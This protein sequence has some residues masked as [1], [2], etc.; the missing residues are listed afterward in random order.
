[1]ERSEEINLRIPGPTPLPPLVRQA[2]SQQM[3]N[4]RGLEFQ[5]L[6]RE[7]TNGLRP[8]FQTTG[9][10]LLFSASGT[11]GMEACVANTVSPGDKVIVVSIGAFGDR[12]AQIAEVYRCQV[13]RLS[14]P[15]GQA[16]DPEAIL[17]ELRS[18]PDC[19][20]VFV[21][22]N[23]TST[24][25]TN[26]L[27]AIG[28]AVR[29]LGEKAPLLVVDAISSL[30]AIELPMDEWG[31]DLVLTASQKAWM[32]PP[33]LA[34]IGVGPRAWAYA[35]RATSPRLYFDF[36]TT[37]RIAQEGYTP[38]TPAVSILYGLRAALKM[39]A[40]EG[41]PN[42]Y[43]R[44]HH[45]GRKMRQGLCGLGFKLVADDAHASDTVTA[46]YLPAGYS[47]G[48]WLERMS[49]D[50]G[51]ILGD[52]QGSLKGKIFRVAHLGYVTDEDIDHVLAAAEALLREGPKNR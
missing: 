3:I 49:R 20:V 38:F 30:G 8:V 25:I 11:G 16:A 48:E 28:T 26:D 29:S 18:H 19:R 10:I 44:H 35:A 31:C 27:Q 24:G 33:G 12:F 14:F 45:L 6:L 32:S 23:E 37:Q 13:V 46:A 47:S 42:V 40:Q 41:L 52:G 1:M 9:D 7:V 34:M 5:S 21:T 4:H 39:M 15:W 51:I 17:R 2:T 22:H 43:A 50:H 36:A